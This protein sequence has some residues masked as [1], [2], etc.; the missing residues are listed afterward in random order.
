MNKE[1]IKLRYEDIYD[2]LNESSLRMIKSTFSVYREHKEDIQL[3]ET[4]NEVLRQD[5]IKIDDKLYDVNLKYSDYIKRYE[6]RIDVKESFKKNK[7]LRDSLINNLYRQIDSFSNFLRQNEIF[8][9]IS[10]ERY[11]DNFNIETISMIVSDDFYNSL[12]KYS[13]EINNKNE[14]EMN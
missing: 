1:F 5:D 14:S 6:L 7:T 9:E 4:I 8:E 13:D 11:H 2:E 3:L 10:L 12:K